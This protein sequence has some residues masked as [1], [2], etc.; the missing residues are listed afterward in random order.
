LESV[1]YIVNSILPGRTESRKTNVAETFVIFNKLSW[2]VAYE[3]INCIGVTKGVVVHD[4][5]RCAGLEMWLYSLLSL[6]LDEAE[7]SVSGPD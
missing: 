2:F 4:I 5:E 3:N 6:A 7:W 1:N